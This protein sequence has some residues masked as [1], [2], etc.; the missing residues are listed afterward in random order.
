MDKIQININNN[1]ENNNESVKINLV[2]IIFNLKDL[3]YNDENK[4]FYLF[5]LIEGSLLELQD[6]NIV[7]IKENKNEMKKNC[8]FDNV[9]MP[10]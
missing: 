4:K 6:C 8:R 7:S 5:E 10:S 9:S 2:K 1:D 3:N